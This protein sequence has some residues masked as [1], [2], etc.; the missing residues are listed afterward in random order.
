MNKEIFS[1]YRST[2]P[3]GYSKENSRACLFCKKIGFSQPPGFSPDSIADVVKENIIW[4]S[5]LLNRE[6]CLHCVNSTAWI[7]SLKE[8]APLKLRI[9]KEMG[10]RE[11]KALW[12][13][14]NSRNQEKEK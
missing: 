6:C 13:S 14:L 10:T 3:T 1:K 12:N 8:R 11:R 2:D 7:A 9:L 4:F 5:T